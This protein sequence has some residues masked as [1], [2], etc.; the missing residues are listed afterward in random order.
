MK[1]GISTDKLL[2]MNPT[3]MQQMNMVN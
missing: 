3:M 2:Q 1:K